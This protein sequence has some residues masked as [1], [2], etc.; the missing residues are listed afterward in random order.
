VTSGRCAAGIIA[1]NFVFAR[2]DQLQPI[3]SFGAARNGM[4][5]QTPTFAEVTA[6]QKLAFTESI[7]VFAS[8]KLDP[9]VAAA[10][11]RAFLSAGQ[12]RDVVD[13]AEAEELPLAIASPEILVE[14]MKRNER[15]LEELL[16]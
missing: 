4:L 11:S 7:G 10:L 15:V 2:L 1:T 13:G 16:G 8:P 3:V 14:T 12:S 6:D 9:A 5:S